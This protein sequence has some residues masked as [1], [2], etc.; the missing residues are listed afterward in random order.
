MNENGLPNYWAGKYSKGSHL[1]NKCKT[2][3]RKP[4]G[5]AKVLT[6]EDISSAFICLCIGYGIAIITFAIE[7]VHSAIKKYVFKITA[8]LN[9]RC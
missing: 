9:P 7:V 6:L 4:I 5:E 3:E 1:H 2:Q 8:E